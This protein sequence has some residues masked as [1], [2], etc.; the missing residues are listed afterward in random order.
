MAELGNILQ[1]YFPSNNMAFSFE[2]LN[3]LVDDL[4]DL[5]KSFDDMALKGELKFLLDSN[6]LST[7]EIID[8]QDVEA[9]KEMRRLEVKYG[10]YVLMMGIQHLISIGHTLLKDAAYVEQRKEDIRAI[11]DSK[12]ITANGMCMVVDC[13]SEIAKLDLEQLIK[14]VKTDYI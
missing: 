9:H 14:F 2:R 11:G 6:P 8:L 4:Y 10:T 1:R 12:W 13:A 3:S 7:T 5:T